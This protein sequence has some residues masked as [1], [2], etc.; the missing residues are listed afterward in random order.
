METT[1]TITKERPRIYVACLAAYNNGYLHGAWIDA[2]RDAWAIWAD[3][4]DI[5]ARSPIPG[6]EEHA[7]HDYEGFEGVRIAEYM[8]IEQVAEIAAFIAEHGELGAA[9]LDHYSSDM[10]EAREALTDRYH[11]CH[12]SLADYVQELTEQTTAIPESL[13][14]YIDWKAMARDVEMSGDLFSL[15][16]AHDEV[17]VFSGC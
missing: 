9:L 5:L 6:A 15:E 4:R 3:I 8:G 11:G 14:Y 2:D 16:L 13:R 12:A 7:I 1:L 10:D 17:H